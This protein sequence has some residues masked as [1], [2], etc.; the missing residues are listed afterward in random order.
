MFPFIETNWMKT[1]EEK[2]KINP[3]VS[4]YHVVTFCVTKGNDIK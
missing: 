3:R 4:G 2:T 1:D